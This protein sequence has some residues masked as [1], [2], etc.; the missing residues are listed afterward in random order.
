MVEKYI[1]YWYPISE[2]PDM[3]CI[4]ICVEKVW[5]FLSLVDLFLSRFE[6][7]MKSNIIHFEDIFPLVYDRLMRVV[8]YIFQSMAKGKELWFC[9]RILLPTQLYG[10]ILKVVMFLNINIYETS[11]PVVELSP[12]CLSKLFQLLSN[13]GNIHEDIFFKWCFCLKGWFLKLDLLFCLC[14][15]ILIYDVLYYMVSLVNT[16][17]IF[18][19]YYKDIEDIG[20]TPSYKV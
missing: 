19:L 1:C 3:V 16:Y 14:C 8:Y 12:I 20:L 9:G 18:T 10:N 5:I 4:T 6:E 2:I 13:E 11:Y 17:A 7:T 15:S